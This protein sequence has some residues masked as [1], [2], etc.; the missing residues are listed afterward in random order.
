MSDAKVTHIDDIEGVYGGIFKPVGR[1]LGVTAF[2]VNVQV[3]GPGDDGYPDHDHSK[4]GQEELYYV[5]SGAATLTI[6]GEPNDLRAGSIAYV[7]AGVSRKFTTTD[8]GVEFIS[9]GGA[10]DTPFTEIIAA[11]EAAKND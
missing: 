1:T 8:S 7:P 10:P 2:G 3:R 4:D 5:L 9:I 11:R 6:D